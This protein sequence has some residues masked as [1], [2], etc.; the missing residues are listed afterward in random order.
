MTKIPQHSSFLL[1]GSEL[2]QSLTALIHLVASSGSAGGGDT[3]TLTS[4]DDSDQAGPEIILYRDSATPDDGDYL[5]Q[6]Q[7]K[8]KNSNSA[9]EIYGKITGKIRD[10]TLGTE[11]GII[12]TAVKGNG[13]FTIVS[14]QRNDELQLING[15]GLSVDGSLAASG[16][17]YP[18]S[19]GTT[20]QVLQTNGAGIISFA[21]AGMTDLVDD[22]TPQLGGDLDADG[23]AIKNIETGT[24]TQV[25]S[26]A[27][28]V[29]LNA[30]SG[31]ITMFDTIDAV[32]SEAFVFTNSSIAATSIVLLTVQ[33]STVADV[34][35]SVALVSVSAGSCEICVTNHDGSNATTAEPVIHFFVIN[36]A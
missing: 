1:R 15:V 9:D 8:G 18:T 19:D 12:E 28:S 31:K 22:T 24:V 21:N 34:A 30:Q 14:R 4:T 17:T 16:L 7:F 20:G 35:P 2:E 36:P 32:T 5:G 29:T 25:T 33:A 10:V 26:N 3:L 13:T 23:N 6:I 27:T 11:D